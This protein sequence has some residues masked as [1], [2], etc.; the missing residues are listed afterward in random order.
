MRVPD[1]GGGG[2]R[3]GL[4]KILQHHNTIYAEADMLAGTAQ[5][6][7]FGVAT[8]LE[9]A[10]ATATRNFTCTKRAKVD[11]NYSTD[12]LLRELQAKLFNTLLLVVY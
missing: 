7:I 8:P 11:D 5:S 4:E 3:E 10:V 9:I 1:K 12:I 2:R 6:P